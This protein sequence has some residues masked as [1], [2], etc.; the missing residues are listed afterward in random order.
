M[1]T[2]FMSYNS[3]KSQALDIDFHSDKIMPQQVHICSLKDTIH[4][5]LSKLLKMC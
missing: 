5:G 1:L 3:G 4:L 2:N